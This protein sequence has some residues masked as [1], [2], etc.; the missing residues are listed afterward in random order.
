[1]LPG[2][3]QMQ[4]G[5]VAGAGLAAAFAQR[6]STQIG[7]A[8]A[9]ALM[10]VGVVASDAL[11]RFRLEKLQ[12]ADAA[13][14]ASMALPSVGLVLCIALACGALLGGVAG[15]WTGAKGGWAVSLV[16]AWSLGALAL[17]RYLGLGS[18]L[19][20]F[21]V[22]IAV[23]L[24]AVWVV[25][26]AQEDAPWPPL[27][28]VVLTLGLAGAGFSIGRGLGL[29]VAAVACAAALIA[30]PRTAPILGPL[31][32]L[33]LLRVAREQSESL[34]AIDVLH[35]QTAMGLVLGAALV[36]VSREAGWSLPLPV[37]RFSSSLGWMVV[38]GSAIAVCGYV[39]GPR[40]T[41]AIVLGA[42][43]GLCLT[44]ARAAGAAQRGAG[45]GVA[46]MAFAVAGNPWVAKV[47][48]ESSRDQRLGGMA[49]SLLGVGLGFLG[50]VLG[51]RS[52]VVEGER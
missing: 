15:R 43:V 11:G 14:N 40:A 45:L 17:A 39:L 23:G 36:L 46:A 22:A 8:G 24:V 20:V 34:R 41:L 28:A 18:L 9:V 51:G 1:L 3:A 52:D 44:H 25:A 37:R 16:G 42:G 31:V 50:I 48:E 7:G 38:V 26:S 49:A 6:R 33:V 10:V 30:L 35:H 29:S 5:V 21:T 12:E 47:F 32:A 4:L 2:A 19:G 27:L 13:A